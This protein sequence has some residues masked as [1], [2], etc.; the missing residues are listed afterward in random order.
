MWD[1]NSQLTETKNITEDNYDTQ[2]YNSFK[3]TKNADYMLNMI[4]TSLSLFKKVNNIRAQ[5][6][7]MITKLSSVPGCGI[8]EI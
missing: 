8:T 2:L 3:L 6:R 7:P 1:L 4:P 5:R